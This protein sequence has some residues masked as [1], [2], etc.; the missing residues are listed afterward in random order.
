MI[1]HLAPGL[2]G[3][4]M[5]V[6]SDPLGRLLQPELGPFTFTPIARIS[7]GPVT[8]LVSFNIVLGATPP[9]WSG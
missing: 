6:V 3:Y 8:Y 5:T 7:R 9:G 2:G 1:G 4:G